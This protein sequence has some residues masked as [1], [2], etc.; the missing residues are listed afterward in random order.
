MVC[1]MNNDNQ[2]CQIWRKFAKWAK[3]MGEWATGFLHM[4][5]AKFDSKIPKNGRNSRILE[6]IASFGLFLP[7][8]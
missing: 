7:K 6:K 2:C 3:F 4:A 5:M 1:P 8:K